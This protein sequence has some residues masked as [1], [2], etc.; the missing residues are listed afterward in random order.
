VA[1]PYKALVDERAF[2]NL[3]GFYD[4]AYVVAYVE[5]TSERTI[6]R[7][8]NPTPR[9]ILEI[10]DCTNRVNL[11]FDVDSDLALENSL[12]KVET[13]I[14]ALTRFREGLV[15][16]GERYRRRGRE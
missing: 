12:H 1:N 13:L 6:A 11:E 16:E 7:Q 2:L 3:P 15:V 4:G 5:D 9:T 10:A 8:V 14:R